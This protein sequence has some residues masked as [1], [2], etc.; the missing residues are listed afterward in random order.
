[1]VNLQEQQLI[2][3]R[4]PIHEDYQTETNMTTGVLSPLA[5]PSIQL[6]VQCLLG[7]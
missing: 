4:Y 6:S 1:M 7:G 2:I 5:F 3:F